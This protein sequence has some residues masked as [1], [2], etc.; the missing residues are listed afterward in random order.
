MC[1]PQTS[2]APM[3]EG[4]YNYSESRGVTYQSLSLATSLRVML[5]ASSSP[6]AKARYSSSSFCRSISSTSHCSAFSCSSEAFRGGDGG[7]REV[8]MLVGGRGVRG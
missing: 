6:S 7:N 1:G 3:S 8:M 4:T 5:V 2:S